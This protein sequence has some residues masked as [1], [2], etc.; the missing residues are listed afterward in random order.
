MKPGTTPADL[1]R[2][3]DATT[4]L[5]LGFYPARS[6]SLMRPPRTARRLIRF[7]E[8]NPAGF[9]RGGEGGGEPVMV[10]DVVEDQV[11]G[12]DAQR[13]LEESESFSNLEYRQL[14]LRL[15]YHPNPRT[16]SAGAQPGQACTKGSC[17]RGS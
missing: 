4:G 5:D 8:R 7:R 11:A 3:P 6:Y 9:G 15:T 14:A 1:H 17:L 16:V 12:P 10:P 2:I 13:A